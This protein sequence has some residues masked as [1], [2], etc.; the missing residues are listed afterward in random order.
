[1]R[2]LCLFCSGVAYVDNNYIFTTNSG[3]AAYALDYA[4]FGGEG[5]EE[6]GSPNLFRYYLKDHLGSTRAV[7]A[8]DVGSG[9]LV[10]ATGYLPYGTQV[11]I[12]TPTANEAAR[13]K[14]TGKELDKDG[15]GTDVADAGTNTVTGVQLSY[16]GARYFDAM[17]GMWVACDPL[18]QYHSPFNYC[19]NNPIKN[20]D[21]DGRGNPNDE[22]GGEDY[23]YPTSNQTG[24]TE[25]DIAFTQAAN[26]AF[27]TGTAICAAPLVIATAVTAAPVIAAATPAVADAVA[28]TATAVGT[29]VV[30]TYLQ[31][32]AAVVAA[33]QG[34][35][36]LGGVPGMG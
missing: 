27:V 5:R 36:A 25:A 2:S 17:T 15:V 13:E 35:G 28:T 10:E 1:M 9:Q 30:Q 11:A 29:N 20:K 33:V 24:P 18:S 31:N 4:L 26:K 34:V 14:F 16:F 32:P 12:I 19:G 23:D 7:W 8:P 6:F 3:I 21:P 22:L